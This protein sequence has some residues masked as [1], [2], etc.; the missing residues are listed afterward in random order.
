MKKLFGII[1]LIAVMISAL[2]LSSCGLI[3]SS[4]STE[5][6]TTA[7]PV[8]LVTPA[9][10]AKGININKDDPSTDDVKFT[11]DDEGKLVLIEYKSGDYDYVASYNYR[12]GNVE[13]Y[14]YGGDQ[15][16]DFLLYEPSSEFD[17]S[18][19]MFEQDGYFFK[20]FKSLTAKEI[21]TT[22]AETESESAPESGT[23]SATESETESES[24]SK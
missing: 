10:A 19:G 7:A 11:F 4:Q 24:A 14:L 20:G 2:T 1:L 3:G 16:V 23:E 22:A 13:V 8:P 17:A 18:L 12:D 6:T 15:V 21:V 9:E 5:T